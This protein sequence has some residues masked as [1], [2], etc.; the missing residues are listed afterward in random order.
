MRAGCRRPTIGRLKDAWSEEHARWSKRDLSAKRYVYFWVDG[1]HVQ[2]RLEDDRAVPAGHH[3]R[4]AGGQE[5]AGRPDRRRARERAIL[6]ELLLDLKR[7]GLVDRARARGRRRRARLLAGGRGSV[8]EDPRP[9]LLGAQDR[10]CAQQ[11][12]EEPAI[13]G[14]AGAAGDLDGRDQEGCARAFDAFVETWG[15]KYDKAVECLI[16]DRD[17]LLAFYDF[18]AEHWKHLRTTNVIESSFA[19]VRHRT[20]RSKGCLSNKTAL[21]MIFKLAEAAEKNWRRLDG[22]NQLPKVILGVKFTDGIE[23][24]RSQAQAAAARPRPSPKFGDMAK[25]GPK[26]LIGKNFN[27][28]E[29]DFRNDLPRNPEG[30]ALIGDHRNDENLLVAQT[31]LAMLK[32]HN[33]VCD[34]LAGSRANPPADIFGE[35]RQI[36]TWHYQWIVLHD[37]VERLTEEDRRQDP[38]RRAQVLPL[39]E[40]ALHAGRVLG[41]RLPARPLAWCASAYRHNKVSPLAELPPVLH[42]LRACRAASSATSLPSRRGR[43]LPIGAQQLDHRLAALLRGTAKRRRPVNARMSRK[44]DPYL[45]HAADLPDGGGNL[46]F[47]QPQAR[48][49]SRL[50][51]GQDVAK[52]MRV[53]NPLTPAEIASDRNGSTDGAVAKRQGLHTATPLW[54][55]IL[56]EAKVQHDGLRAGT[57]RLDDRLGS[58][59]RPRARRPQFHMSI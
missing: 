53:K 41:G 18:P 11:A 30:F 2:A 1:I 7:R 16:K 38:A 21:A 25:H 13:E 12:A 52:H 48:R 20:V 59:R 35:A 22:H 40:D 54:Y 5:G 8:A 44:L 43:R 28:G 42:L 9:A 17:A 6:E 49:Q 31:H 36:V 23:V 26:L 15:V 19:T 39:Q 14:Q 55:Y 37:W 10:Q 32:F 45:V 57:G 51:V 33:K 3:R 29:G 47:P 27:T 46:A 24:V 4:H 50:A 58:V 56:K 34:M